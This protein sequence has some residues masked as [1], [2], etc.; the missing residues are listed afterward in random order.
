VASG[1]R[2]G[3]EEVAMLRRVL[4]ILAAAADGASARAAVIPPLVRQLLRG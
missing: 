3:S 2:R 4:P 1:G